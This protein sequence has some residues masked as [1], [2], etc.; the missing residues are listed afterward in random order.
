MQASAYTLD[1]ITTVYLPRKVVQ[2]PNSIGTGATSFF[3]RIV[4]YYLLEKT[5]FRGTLVEANKRQRAT[6]HIQAGDDNWEP[7]PDEL[8]ALVALFQQGDLD[9]LGAIIATRNSIQAQEIR[10]GGDFWKIN[11][12]L[13]D[14]TAIKLR[15]LG[16]SE[17][18]LSGETNY[19]TAEVGLSVFV[20]SINAYRALLTHIIFY[21]KLFPIISVVNK[22]YKDIKGMRVTDS[23]EDFQF[24]IN[25]NSKLIIP[26]LN[27]HKSLNPRTD[28][29]MIDMLQLM[30]EKGVPIPLRMWAASSGVTIESLISD[31]RDDAAIRAEIN[32]YKSKDEGGGEDYGME[33]SML[34]FEKGAMKRVGVLNRKFSEAASEI[35]RRTKTGQK[36]WVHNQHAAHARQNDIIVKA[37]RSIA[38]R[39]TRFASALTRLNHANPYGDCTLS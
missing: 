28:K 19:S 17:A 35:T 9:P 12:V 10:Q 27:W 7:T 38:T 25:D 24:N 13:G 33:E 26:T 31:L 3:K 29:D 20:E 2:E 1:P 32:K 22:F 6:L 23:V 16:I 21:N 11:D 14:T 34:R 4:P 5:L 15:A 30:S 39:G 36:Q 8:Q 18:F 37:A